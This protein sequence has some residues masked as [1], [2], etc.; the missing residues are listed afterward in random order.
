[1]SVVCNATFMFKDEISFEDIP[2]YFFANSIVIIFPYVRAF[3]STVS[4]QSN[5]PAIVLPTMNLSSLQ[6]ELKNNTVCQ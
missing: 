3:V 2:P 6:D 5:R 4:L 1:M